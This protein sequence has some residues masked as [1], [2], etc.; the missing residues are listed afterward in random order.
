MGDHVGVRELLNAADEAAKQ[1]GADENYYW[2]AF[3]PTNAAFYRAAANV[4]L[5]E[6]GRAVEVHTAIDQHDFGAMV[7][8]RRASHL[9]NVSRGLV[10]VGDI[11]RAG[12]VLMEAARIAPSEIRCRPVAHELITDLLRLSRSTSSPA[13]QDLADHLGLTA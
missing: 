5:G 10:Q 6:G 9:L 1:V 11:G 12:E 7:P 4:E 3:G 2:T 13:V 8:E